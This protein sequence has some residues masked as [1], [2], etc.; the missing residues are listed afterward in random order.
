MPS[1]SPSAP[2]PAPSAPPDDCA[3]TVK[4]ASNGS[5]TVSGGPGV[6]QSPGVY[7]WRCGT[8]ALSAVSR[9]D[10]SQKKASSVVVRA[11]ASS[12][13]DLR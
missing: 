12:V 1:P 11:G 2:S 10:P 5:Y 13:V 7:T 4:I 6:V 9:A 8:Y 3:G